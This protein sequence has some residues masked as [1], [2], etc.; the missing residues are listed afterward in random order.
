MAL[1]TKNNDMQG[2]KLRYVPIGLQTAIVKRENV[3]MPMVNKN[4]EYILSPKSKTQTNLKFVLMEHFANNI[5][6]HKIIKKI[7]NLTNL[8]IKWNNAVLLIPI[9]KQNIIDKTINIELNLAK[10]SI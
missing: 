9:K 2:I 3:D 5:F 8:K 1:R 10:N 6:F 4:L 7:I